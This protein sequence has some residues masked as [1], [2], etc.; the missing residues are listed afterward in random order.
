[1]GVAEDLVVQLAAEVREPNPLAGQRTGGRVGE[2]E[3]DR[4]PERHPDEQADQDDRRRDEERGED[5]PTLCRVPQPGRSQSVAI[6]RP[7][8]RASLLK[9]GA[10][11]PRSSSS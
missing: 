2:A 9:S 3:V 8:R 5:T 1:E 11:W 7:P 10:Q 6:H 4:E